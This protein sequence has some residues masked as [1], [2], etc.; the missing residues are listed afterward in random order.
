MPLHPVHVRPAPET[1]PPASCCWQ[2]HPPIPSTHSVSVQHPPP[3]TS[4]SAPPAV[5]HRPPSA[6]A[7]PP[8]ASANGELHLRCSNPRRTTAVIPACPPCWPP[9]STDNWCGR[10]SAFAGPR[11]VQCLLLQMCSADNF[12]KP[13]GFQIGATPR[14]TQNTCESWSRA[15]AQIAGSRLGHSV[16][17]V[18]TPAWA[19][20]R[21][22]LHAQ[23]GC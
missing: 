21:R 4:I 5:H 9:R 7:P 10:R 3:S 6:P 20:Q 11:A 22:S 23:A 16:I 1:A 8:A 12:Q 14:Q 15:Y 2:I 13:P 19:L 17:A 18:T